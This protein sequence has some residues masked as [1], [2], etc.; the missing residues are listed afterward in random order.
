MGSKN[1][2]KSYFAP[3]KSKNF[4]TKFHKTPIFEIDGGFGIK[5]LDS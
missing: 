4:S 5:I 2:S 1:G 3:Q